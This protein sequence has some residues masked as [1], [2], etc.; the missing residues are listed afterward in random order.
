MFNRTDIDGKKFKLGWSHNLELL[1]VSKITLNPGINIIVDLDIEHL[2]TN[3]LFGMSA[4]I[5]SLSA[6]Y[7]FIK[8]GMRLKIK[9]KK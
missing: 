1:D 9:N 8:N 3:T 5:I 2:E 7:Y 4:L 6:G